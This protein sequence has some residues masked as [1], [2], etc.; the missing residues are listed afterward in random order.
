M[1]EIF[2][3][4]LDGTLLNSRKEMT[5]RT[6]EALR[7]L[8]DAGIG[9]VICTGRSFLSFK[10]FMDELNPSFPII[11]Q[12]GAVILSKDGRILRQSILRSDVVEKLFELFGLKDSIIFTFSK[13][14]PDRFTGGFSDENPFMKYVDSTRKLM[15]FVDDPKNI[16]RMNIE[17]IEV[18]IFRKKWMG[19]EIL[20]KL[21]SANLSGEVSLIVS[22]F[23]SDTG[24]FEI[25]GPEVSK[26]RAL[27]FLEKHLGISTKKMVFIG[28]N[29]NDIDAMRIAGLSVA[30]GNSPDEV[31]KVA[32]MV[33]P[34]C[35]EEGVSY[36]VRE[37]MRGG[38][39]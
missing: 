31:K 34:S 26:G 12:N 33:V 9:V 23:L 22:N 28:D 8:E 29:Y 32:D 16:L 18:G 30:M 21:N 37:M 13:T 24:F 10:P 38:L 2:V 36:L 1:Y 27:K 19:V 4:D 39:K 5:D 3:F 14:S 25:F 15:E 7:T 11:L 20:E 17:F 35:D 6:I